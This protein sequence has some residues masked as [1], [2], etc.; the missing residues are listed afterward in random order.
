MY[1]AHYEPTGVTRGQKDADHGGRDRVTDDVLTRHADLWQTLADGHTPR[2]LEA[3][4]GFSG[5]EDWWKR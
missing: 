5:M 4:A 3:S 1:A 2:D